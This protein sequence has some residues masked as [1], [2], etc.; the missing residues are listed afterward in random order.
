MTHQPSQRRFLRWAGI[1]LVL[2]VL[3]VAAPPAGN[4]YWRALYYYREGVESEGCAQQFEPD[5]TRLA[6]FHWG[7]WPVPGWVCEFEHNGYRWERRLR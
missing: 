2:V 7:W 5:K 3:V 1:L 4:Y 6:G